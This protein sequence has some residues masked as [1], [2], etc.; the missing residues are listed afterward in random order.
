[1]KIKMERAMIAEGTSGK[2]TQSS[3][4][5][6]LFFVIMCF[7]TI[8]LCKAQTTIYRNNVGATTGTSS[9]QNNWNGG[10]TTTYRNN[11]GATTGTSTTQSNWNGG[12]TT[13]HRNNVG[14]VTG[15]STTQSNWDGTTT[16]THRNNVGT[17]I[18]T[19]TR[20]E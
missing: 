9:T 18:G 1:M 3:G 19:T 4:K 13:T 11:V 5:K 20:R 10:T 2:M 7:L 6:M 16:T 17:V 12:T 15:T 14:S 8:S